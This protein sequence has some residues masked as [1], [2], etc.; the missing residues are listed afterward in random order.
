[1]VNRS[2]RIS[3]WLY[4]SKTF[5]RLYGRIAGGMAV[6]IL[7]DD[8]VANFLS[9]VPDGATLLEIGAGPG[10]L[11]IKV[12]ENRP[13]VRIVVTDVS[14]GMLGLAK[15]NL[16]KASRDNVDIAKRM[17]H[18][19]YVL[20]NAM[21]L[22][23]FANRAI[24]GI[25]SM[26][27]IKHFPDPVRCL[28]QTE[29]ILAKGGVMYFTD[30]CADGTSSGIRE[31]VSKLGVPAIMRPLVRRIVH[32]GIKK[33]APSRD[34]VKSWTNQ[35][36]FGKGSQCTFSASGV[37]FALVYQKPGVEEKGSLNNSVN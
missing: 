19:E 32:F 18:L 28:S 11:A 17:D 36:Q 23:Q 15:E 14:P 33:E 16:L 37:I 6:N 31:L 22:S 34:E 4:R 25:Y 12:L 10:I 13:D 5:T 1:M 2:H 3:T 7:W 24:D 35:L 26:G 27:A 8:F 9:R 20:A 29:G 30:F 21:D